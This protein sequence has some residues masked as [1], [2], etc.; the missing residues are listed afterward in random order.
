MQAGG[1]GMLRHMHHEYFG[2][3]IDGIHSKF[4]VL[5]SAVHRIGA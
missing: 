3:C 4:I 5:P 2:I 1:S